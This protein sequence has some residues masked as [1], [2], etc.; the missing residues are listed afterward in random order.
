MRVRHRIVIDAVCP[1]N[2]DPDTYVCDV[3]PLTLLFCETVELWA[4]ELT[5][6]P[7]TQEWLTQQLADKLGCAVRTKGTHCR[8]KVETVCICH[9]SPAQQGRPA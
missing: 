6:E 5:E 3:Y 9:P 2:G 4:R 8:G 7:V 1:V